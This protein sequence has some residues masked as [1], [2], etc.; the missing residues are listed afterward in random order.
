LPERGA[1]E[2]LAAALTGVLK[3][4]DPPPDVL[5]ERGAWGREPL[6]H[7]LGTDPQSVAEKVLAWKNASIAA[8]KLAAN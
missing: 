2:S 4:G 1:E 5:Q 3:P 7:F 8:G 6:L